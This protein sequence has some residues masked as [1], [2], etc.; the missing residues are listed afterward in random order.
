LPEN[1]KGACMENPAGKKTWE[2]AVKQPAYFR[3][4]RAG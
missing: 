2:K 4:G 3:D 1:K